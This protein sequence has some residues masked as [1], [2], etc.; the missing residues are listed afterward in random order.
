MDS[1]DS[2]GLFALSGGLRE[3]YAL[4]TTYGNYEEVRA[5]VARFFLSPVLR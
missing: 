5:H 1:P 3:A 2:F 4:G